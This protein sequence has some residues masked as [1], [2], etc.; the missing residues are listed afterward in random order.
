MSVVEGF[1]VIIIAY[2]CQLKEIVQ[3]IEKR[4][5]SWF[6]ESYGQAILLGTFPPI[7]VAVVQRSKL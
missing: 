2:H 3:I 6:M 1:S 4:Q 7:L 5:N